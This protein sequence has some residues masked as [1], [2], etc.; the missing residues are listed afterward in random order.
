MDMEGAF[1]RMNAPVILFTYNRPWHT[2]QTVEAL[3]KNNLADESELIVF[4][5][6]PKDAQDKEKV[7]KVRQYI[8]SVKGFG[9]VT[10]IERSEN[11]GLGKSII[12]GISEVINKYEK[13][14]VLEDDLVTAPFFLRYM[15]EALEL[16]KDEEKVISVHGYIYPVIGN[17]PVTFF[18]RGADCWGWGTW[19]RGW[20]LFEENGQKLLENLKKDHLTN[21][22]DFNGAYGYTKMLKDQIKGRNSSWAVRWHASAFINDLLTLYPGVSL[23]RHIGND[24]SGTNFDVSTYGDTNLSETPVNLIKIEPIENIEA[25]KIVSGY[26]RSMKEPLPRLFLNLLKKK[27]N[28]ILFREMT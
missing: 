12:N 17:L 4:S 16:Y 24:G 13:I 2:R 6:G 10:V 11:L 25:K 20:A 23:V 15:N 9:N 28:Q 14:I 5:D 22:F 26:L 7:D 1:L 19:K 8:R 18:L 27:V 21:Q 3:L